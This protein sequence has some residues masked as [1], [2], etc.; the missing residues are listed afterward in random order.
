MTEKPNL[1]NR[2]Q[3]AILQALGGSRTSENEVMVHCCVH[4]DPNPSLSV[5]LKGE[6]LLVRC[7]AGCDQVE[8]IEALKLR[9]LWPESGT[10]TNGSGIPHAWKGK[11]RTGFWE[12]R[13]LNGSLLGYVARF[14]GP[15]G[16]DV[17]PYFV[18]N[19]I[20]WKAG[21]APEPRPLYGLHKLRDHDVPVLIVEGEKSADAAQILAQGYACITWPGGSNA[22]RKANFA[23]LAGRDVI[24]WPDADEPGQKAARAVQE[25][26]EHIGAA[27]VRILTP[28][29]GVAHGWDAAD[30]VAE[31]WTPERFT[32]FAQGGGQEPDA[33]KGIF[34][35]AEL[36]KMQLPEIR[37]AVE[38]LLPQGLAILAGG[39]KLGKSWLIYSVCAAVG[40]GGLVLGHFP[41][42]PGKALYLALE[43]SKRRLQDRLRSL[44]EIEP[45]IEAG[46]GN[47]DFQT[48]WPRFDDEGG[49]EHLENY[50]AKNVEQGLK[51]VVIDTAAKVAPKAKSKGLNA[52]EN[53]SIIMSRIKSLADK[54]G[55]CI[56]I[57]THLNKLKSSNRDPFDSITGSTGQFGTADTALLL[58][59][60]RGAETAKLITTGRD[61]DGESYGLRW[62]QPGWTCT[63]VD[64]SG[65]ASKITPERQEILELFKNSDG[66]M[67]PAMVANALNKTPN[68]TT[69]LIKKLSLEGVLCCVGYGLYS[70]VDRQSGQSV[71]GGLS[72]QSGLSGE[73]CLGVTRGRQSSNAGA[74]TVCG[75]NRGTMPTMPSVLR[76]PQIDS[77]E[78]LE[79]EVEL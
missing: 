20:G 21:A 65:E 40:M 75:R 57:V 23:P 58:V 6:K 17:V 3:D 19:G 71:H 30:A 76:E 52:Y 13:D 33:C 70:L 10:S 37:W 31:G 12:Y 46:L 2:A 77:T 25:V 45:C 72:G 38:G 28:P 73:L 60:T 67:S 79:M 54:H 9:S 78:P 66:P 26:L 36:L 29:A 69:K 63:G 32:Q 51:L 1:A 50:V 64:H 39:P 61:I 59:R 62:L 53:D 49:L 56:L 7:F 47:V 44:I 48:T 4:N 68:S 24:V 22:V 35:G 74:P 34:N 15:E 42:K 16:K 14:D 41:S 11:P 27:S 5:T 55:I 18:R 43:D 8:V